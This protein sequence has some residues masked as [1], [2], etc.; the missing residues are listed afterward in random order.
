MPMVKS[1]WR[2]LSRLL[3]EMEAD[4][5]ATRVDISMNHRNMLAALDRS[6]AR[7]EAL[8]DRLERKT[9]R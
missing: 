2:L 3:R 8:F 5:R 9:S 6:K 7:F 4:V 1:D